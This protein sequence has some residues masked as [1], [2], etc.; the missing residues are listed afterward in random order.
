MPL[1]RQFIIVEGVNQN[2][3][4]ICPLI[5][6]VKLKEEHRYRLIVEESL[7][8]G[9]LGS[10]GGGVADFLNINPK[11]IDILIASLSNAFCSAGG[12]CA[13]SREI[14]EHQRLSGQ[15]YTFSASMPALVIFHFI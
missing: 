11:K 15:S 9:V 12:I 7:S 2:T 4:Q 5:E 3:G 10:R 14:V 6:L 1:R 13:G 8:L